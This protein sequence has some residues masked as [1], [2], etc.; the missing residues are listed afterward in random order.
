ILSG[1]NA[2]FGYGAYGVWNW[3]RA[4]DESAWLEVFGPSPTCLEGLALP[5]AAETGLSAA[6][7]RELGMRDLEP[8]PAEPDEP[9]GLAFARLG[10]GRAWLAYSDRP[11]LI[12]SPRESMSIRVHAYDFE[13]GTVVYPRVEMTRDGDFIDLGLTSG[14]SL[15]VM[16]SD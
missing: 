16:E 10:E 7:W 12:S 9:E 8:V 1:A 3:H 15:V 13:A 2:G 14:D 4:G 6:L 11:R 5:G